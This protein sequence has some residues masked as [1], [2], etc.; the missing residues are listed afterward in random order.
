MITADPSTWP[1]GDRFWDIAR[2]IAFA[3]GADRSGSNPDRL[4]NPGDISDG[5]QTFGS[6][7]H[8]GSN[9]TKFPDKE[10][11]WQ[12]LYNKIQRAASGGSS[13]FQPGMTWLEIGQHYAPPN[14]QA[15]GSNVAARLGVSPNSTLA[16]YVAGPAAVPGPGSPIP[17][18]L[19]DDETDGG[20]GGTSGGSGTLIAIA[21]VGAG[22]AWFW[23]TRS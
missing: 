7:F 10:T 5:V 20:T 22:L 8:S 11:G 1:T 21:I 19:T 6:E 3:E 9:I 13:V 12:W 14:W 18:D 15:W 16:D 4:N 17:I 2:A 23:A